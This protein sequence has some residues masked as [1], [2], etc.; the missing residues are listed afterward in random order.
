[1]AAFSELP[2]REFKRMISEIIESNGG[3]MRL[4]KLYSYLRNRGF[5][6]RDIIINLQR[7]GI[8]VDEVAD[9]ASLDPE[10]PMQL[11][12]DALIL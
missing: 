12:L 4:S 8:I 6:H 11:T 1:M 3:E 2:R 10:R 7:V 9:V 5:Y